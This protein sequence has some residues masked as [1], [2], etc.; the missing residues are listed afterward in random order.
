MIMNG[1]KT[2]MSLNRLLNVA[3]VYIRQVPTPDFNVRNN[4]S[5]KDARGSCMNHGEKIDAFVLGSSLSN[6]R[7]SFSAPDPLQSSIHS[8]GW[9][10]I[11]KFV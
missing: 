11:E 7:H 1:M 4:Q 6:A 2:K 3:T 8:S 10:R 5:I 9:S